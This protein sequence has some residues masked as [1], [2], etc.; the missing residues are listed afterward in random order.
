[1]SDPATHCIEQPVFPSTPV[2]LAGPA[3]RCAANL[4]PRRL[5]SPFAGTVVVGSRTLFGSQGVTESQSQW[6][7][8]DGV[9]VKY[10]LIPPTLPARSWTSGQD[11]RSV[12]TYLP[13]LQISHLPALS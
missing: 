1:M 11:Y 6:M 13:L 12:Y 5:G 2:P 4:F 10:H 9:R 3:G 8:A 7:D